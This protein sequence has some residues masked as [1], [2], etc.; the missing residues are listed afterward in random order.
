MKAMEQR[1]C[2]EGCWGQI[3]EPETQ[4][5]QKELALD[6]PSGTLSLRDL[7]S[8]LC[9]DLMSSAQGFISSTWTYSLQTD[10]RKVVVF[11]VRG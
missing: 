11:Q 3:P 10:N 8:M 2:S 1:A 4:L 6:P 5:E 9:N 7:F